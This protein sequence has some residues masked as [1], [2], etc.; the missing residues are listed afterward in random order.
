[1]PT[2]IELIQWKSEGLR[3]PNIEV[4]LATSSGRVP[5]VALVQMPNGTGKTTT[6]HCLR[7]AM[8]GSAERWDSAKVKGYQD[9]ENPADEGRFRATLLI[10]RTHRLV[11]EMTFHFAE[12]VVTYTTTS[13][14][15]MS[16]GYSPPPNVRRFL[17]PRFS[18]LLFFDGELAEHLVSGEAHVDASSVIDTFYGLYHL[19]ELRDQARVSYENYVKNR[20]SANREAELTKKQTLLGKLETRRKEVQAQVDASRARASV[21]QKEIESLENTIRSR[22]LSSERYKKEEQAA[23][24]AHSK[25]LDQR[26]SAMHRLDAAFPNPLF[27]CPT[28]HEE[29]RELADHLDELKLP[30]KTSVA[31]IEDLLKQHECICGRPM[32]SEAKVS[33]R[34]KA[35]S[36]LGDDIAA[37]LNEFKHSVRRFHPPADDESFASRFQ[38][39]ASSDDEVAQAESSLKDIRTRAAADEGDQFALDKE[40]LEKAIKARADAEA[41]AEEASRPS[42]PG[43]REDGVC[44]DYFDRRIKQLELEIAEATGSL[45]RKQQTELLTNTIEGA[46]DEAHK[47]LKNSVIADANNQLSQVLSY[48]PVR[49]ASIDRSVRISGKTGVSVGQGLSVGYVFLAGLLH[50]GGNRF[51]FVVDSPAGPLDDEARRHLGGLL[52]K[53]VSQFVGF[54][55]PTERQ[56]FV[57]PLETAAGGDVRYLTLLRLN[58]KVAKRLSDIG[59]SVAQKSD[60]GILLEGR[61][62]FMRLGEDITG[63]QTN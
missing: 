18:E 42:Q 10:D 32:D 19:I 63:A 38:E 47:K 8:D 49:I 22:L 55:I 7:A 20:K 46:Y 33:I 26:K 52:P 34:R 58:E 16:D 31:F 24:D 3:C 54:V 4:L 40:N 37:F 21:L 43:D 59:G 62:A 25:S 15:R 51:P 45:R 57:E 53:L 13:G 50:A 5:Q 27:L 14:S 9:S 48:N 1:M 23:L 56:Y 30:E 36:I 6:L 17:D 41:Y 28:S 2:T 12:G 11:I 39:L 61:D 29:L 60:N 35:D 44:L